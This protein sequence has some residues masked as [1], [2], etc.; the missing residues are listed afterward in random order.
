MPL[1]LKQFKQLPAC[2]KTACLSTTSASII[3][4]CV[5]AYLEITQNW[6]DSAMTFMTILALLGAV[7]FSALSWGYSSMYLKLHTCRRGR[8]V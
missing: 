2:Y 6:H 7:K 4:L 5:C 8:A 1:V 3:L